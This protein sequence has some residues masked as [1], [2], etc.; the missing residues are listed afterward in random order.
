MIRIKLTHAR[1]GP[2]HIGMC[3]VRNMT[4][5]RGIFGAFKLSLNV[6]GI[7]FAIREVSSAADGIND[8]KTRRSNS[9]SD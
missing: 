7:V 2:H 5:T 8:V 6:A 4:L 1:R 3:A 9:S